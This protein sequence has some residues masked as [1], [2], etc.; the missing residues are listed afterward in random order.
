MLQHCL[1]IILII[2]RCGIPIHDY[3]EILMGKDSNW[4]SI[5]DMMCTSDIYNA[6]IVSLANLR[7]GF[8]IMGT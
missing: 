7:G 8:V 4:V 1:I 3:V 5:F 6:Q 2:N